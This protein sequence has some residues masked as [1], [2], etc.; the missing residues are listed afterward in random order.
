MLSRSMLSLP[1]SALMHLPCSTLSVAAQYP[2][3]STCCPVGLDRS[4]PACFYALCCPAHWEP[5]V[6]VARVLTGMYLQL[7][8]VPS[9]VRGYPDV[10]A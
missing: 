3:Q 10:L 2:E 7:F 4:P 1:P 5:A 8:G 9:A 6:D